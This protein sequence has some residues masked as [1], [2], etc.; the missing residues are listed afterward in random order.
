MLSLAVTLAFIA[1]DPTSTLMTEY[2]QAVRDNNA[3]AQAAAF[4][5]LAELREPALKA[6]Q[7]AFESASK[8]NQEP[9]IK[10][11]REEINKLD[12]QLHDETLSAEQRKTIEK[13]RADLRAPVDAIL[14]EI[15]ASLALKAEIPLRSAWADGKPLLASSATAVRSL[16]HFVAKQDWK[17]AATC[18]ESGDE[19]EAKVVVATIAEIRKAATE[20]AHWQEAWAGGDVTAVLFTT[21]KVVRANKNGSVLECDDTYGA[22]LV[23]HAGPDIGWRILRAET[24]SR[25]DLDR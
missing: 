9:K 25:F 12:A 6:A 8:R 14:R 24:G 2:L 16:E 21:A 10:A 11:A 5:K 15:T 7:A 22:V 19:K 13:N 1:Q 17:T 20:G 3:K 4:E 23:K 18:L